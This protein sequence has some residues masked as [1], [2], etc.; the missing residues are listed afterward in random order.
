MSALLLQVT[1]VF[2]AV[3]AVLGLVQLKWPRA[4][5]DRTVTVGLILSLL[6]HALALG[7]RTVELSNFPLATLSDGLSLFGFVV[8]GIAVVLAW[9]SVPQATAL[10]S[11]LVGASVGLAVLVGQP[12]GGATAVRSGWLPVHIAFVF[13]GEGAFAVAGTVAVIYLTQDRRHKNKKR[14]NQTTGTGLNKLPALEILDTV[15]ARLVQLG[16]PFMTIGLLTGA[17]YSERV[18]GVY[19]SLGLLNIVGVT[20]W[21]LFGVL[22]YVRLTIGWRGRKAAVLTLLGVS[23]TMLVLVGLGLAGIG[24]H[25]GGAT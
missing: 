10:A 15:S 3:V 17:I 4:A 6:T 1:A 16:F 2:Y 5:G 9:R 22:L 11:V 25:G 13:L 19:F 23:A 24:A 7:G 18:T 21:A 12:E 20:V 14:R 8:A